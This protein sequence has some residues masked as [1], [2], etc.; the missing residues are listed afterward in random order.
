MLVSKSQTIGWTPPKYV[1]LV[2]ESPS[3]M[4]AHW[5]WHKLE[6]YPIA[7]V[8]GTHIKYIPH[9][10]HVPWRVTLCTFLHTYKTM[11]VAHKLE[12]WHKKPTIYNTKRCKTCKHPS[13]SN[14]ATW[15]LNWN[16]AT[17]TFMG[18]LGN[19]CL[20]CELSFFGLNLHFNL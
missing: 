13:K 1:H 18:D 2:F 9:E 8:H 6:V 7:C 12:S 20:N 16:Q 5:F 11:Y 15:C 4:Y 14:G 10:V 3:K 19:K 17:I